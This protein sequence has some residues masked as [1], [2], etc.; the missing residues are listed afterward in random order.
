[1]ARHRIYTVS[2]ARVYPLY[3]AK[4]EK[5]GRTKAEVDEVIRWLTGYSQEQLEAQLE[6]DADCETFVAEAPRP[7]PSRSL[8]R[9]VVCGVRVEEVAEPT[10]RELRYM[11]KLVDELAKG[12]AMEKILRQAD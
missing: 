2:F 7:N 3:V 4:A 8:I 10:M 1:M 12:K 9:G 11:D 5:K 6:R